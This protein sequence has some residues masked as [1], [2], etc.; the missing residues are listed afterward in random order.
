MYTAASRLGYPGDAQVV[1]NWPGARFPMGTSEFQALLDT[2]HGKGIVYLLV[3]H[4][5]DLGTKN[6]EAITV[7]TA[8][9]SRGIHLL[10]TLT[11]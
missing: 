1:A 10:F 2:P 9:P 4:P 8:R 6:I 3:H 5:N 11:D 7:L